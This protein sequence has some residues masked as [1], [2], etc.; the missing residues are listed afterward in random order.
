MQIYIAIKFYV[1]YYSGSIC[2]FLQTAWQEKLKMYDGSVSKSVLKNILPAM[3]ASLLTLV[4][5]IADTFFIGRTHNDLMLAAVSLATPAFLIFMSLGTL[6]GVGG[7]SVVA[8]SLGAG[9]KKRACRASAFCIWCCAAVGVICMA[10]FWIFMERILILMGASSDSMEYT[11]EYLNI[12]TGCG[13]FSMLVQCLS[14]LIRAEGRP[15]VA[16]AG[17]LFGNILNIILDPV[18][19]L[20]FGWGT[21]GAAIATVIGTTAGAL[22]YIIYI[23]SGKYTL[24]ARLRDFSWKDGI[25]KEVFGIG[26]PAALTTFLMSISQIIANSL[27]SAYGDMAVAAYGVASKVRMCFGIIGAGLGQGLQP[28]LA[29]YYGAGNRQRFK[30]SFRFSLVFGFVLFFVFTVIFFIFAEPIVKVFLTDSTALGYGVIFSRML[31]TVTWVISIHNIFVSVLHATGAKAASFFA[32]IAGQGVIYI[33]LLFI[34]RAFFGLNGLVCAQPVSE[35]ISLVIV[36]ILAEFT[37]RK[38]YR[39]D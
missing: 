2:D 36:I 10:V 33:P 26:I 39:T 1:G 9:N 25:G 4:Y 5:N 22:F 15:G 13:V 11:R 32:A 14:N 21:R 12:V 27:I 19:I 30:K 29:Y 34:L 17:S 7:A 37:V 3:A 6:F 16:M 8:R 35:G 24:S 31:L 18:F 23:V 20:V 38:F 28:L